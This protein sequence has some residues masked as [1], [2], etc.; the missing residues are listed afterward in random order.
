[1]RSTKLKKYMKIP[2]TPPS[3]FQINFKAKKL[4]RM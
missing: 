3:I 1:L 4:L 2:V